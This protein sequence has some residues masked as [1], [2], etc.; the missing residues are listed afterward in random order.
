[1]SFL[2]NKTSQDYFKCQISNRK[3]LILIAIIFLAAFLRFYKLGQ[4]PPGLYWD[5]AVFGYDAYSLL[6]TG[7]DH[8]GVTL[9]LFFESFGD[10]K[11]PA[12]HYLL[13]PS[14]AIFGLNEFAV[15]FPSAF[16]GLA[17]IIIFFLIVKKLTKNIN[18]SLFCALFL[19]IS[20]WHIQFSRGGFEST[21]GLF[22]VTLGLYLFLRGTEK[23]RILLF[24]F[25]FLLFT[26]SMYTYHAYRIFTP[27]FLIVLIF[28]YLEQLKKNIIRLI[29]PTVLS[30]T[31]ISPLLFFTFSSEG[32]SRAISQSA[33]K[34]GDF[35]TAK[36]DFDQKSKK[37][38]RF[39]SKYLYYQPS[40][41][42]SYV[43]TNAYL[44]HLSPVFLFFRG[45]QI[46][47]HSQVDMGQIFLF[48]AILLAI[49][50]FAV[51]KLDKK[52]LIFMVSFLVLA[53]L[54]AIIVTPTPH[55]YRTLQMSIPLAFF[56]GLGAYW[57]FS[58][59]KFLIPKILLAFIIFY[60]FLTYLHLLF[61]HYPRKF[62][63][64]WQDGYKEMVAQVERFQDNYDK[65][66]ITN[67][68]SL[69]YIYLLFYQKYD[70]EK[71]IFQKGT[72]D[73]FDK[74]FFIPDDVDI[75]NK[76][77]ILYIAPPWKKVDGTWLAD[78]NDSSGRHIY[79]LWEV[80]GKI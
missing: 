53:P 79:S 73:S 8:H 15:R 75:Y 34:K 47:R 14:I 27:L 42:Y 29:L 58:N 25:A 20:P 16:F 50:F 38:L 32:K 24:T 33:F 45:D 1:M 37:P 48:E 9:P 74:Y 77:K 17:T 68:N 55:A 39:L 64:D 5:E 52:T 11:L 78:A 35:E 46:G 36:L 19:A 56:S 54:P 26:L 59:K 18:L 28:I 72:K 63:A 30:L 7:K 80:N 6:K 70:P 57:I 44:D 41:Y 12:Y 51:R 4:N 62:A 60:S 43:A 76:G 65:V 69:P 3:L 21:V 71:F 49:S 66:Y 40:F 13:V 22:F 2:Q 31:L 67:I 10:W 23:K 61:I